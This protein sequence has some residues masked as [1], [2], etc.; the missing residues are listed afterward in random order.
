[1]TISFKRKHLVQIPP[2]TINDV[3]LERVS[4]FK[5]LGL[6]I[7]DDLSFQEHTEY[8]CKKEKTPDYT[9]LKD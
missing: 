1:M 3:Q 5:L 9:F 6:K 7:T 8:I 4:S 2:V